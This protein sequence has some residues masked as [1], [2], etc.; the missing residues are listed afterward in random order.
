MRFHDTLKRL[1]L[2]LLAVLV[3]TEATAKP[4]LDEGMYRV[5]WNRKVRDLCIDAYTNEDLTARD[6]SRRGT[7]LRR[8][9]VW[10]S[11]RRR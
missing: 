8:V 1:M 5:D 6:S 7:C 2:P 9:A 4:Q 11:L 3:C 10:R